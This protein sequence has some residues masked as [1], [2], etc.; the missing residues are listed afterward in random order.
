MNRSRV[1]AEQHE[2]LAR[3]GRRAGRQQQ[4]GASVGGEQRPHHQRARQ[5]LRQEVPV[6][7]AVRLRERDGA[8]MPRRGGERGGRRRARRRRV[9]LGVLLVE[10][11]ERGK[12]S[13]PPAVT[14]I[15]PGAF[16]SATIERGGIARAGPHNSGRVAV[17]RVISR[18]ALP[19]ATQRARGATRQ[20]RPSDGRW[21]QS[22]SDCG[23]GAVYGACASSQRDLPLRRR[24]HVLGGGPGSA[25]RG[26]DIDCGYSRGGVKS[27]CEK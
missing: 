8:P 14:A 13:A 21:A 10:T 23:P 16:H 27:S 1:G 18:A 9:V 22:E 4:R 25:R 20:N 11:A 3:G 2:Q 7:G 15:S 26:R 17:A 19:E 24:R 6:V 5:Q 12:Y